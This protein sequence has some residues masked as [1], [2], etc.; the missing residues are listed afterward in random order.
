MD[1]TPPVTPPRTSA[2]LQSATVSGEPCVSTPLLAAGAVASGSVSKRRKT[3]EQL[4][5]VEVL[6]DDSGEL[7][8]DCEEQLAF[9]RRCKIRSLRNV[10]GMRSGEL[11]VVLEAQGW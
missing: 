10:F 4:P 1:R 9:E 7:C 3:H 6:D 5:V 11:A 8:H 2:V